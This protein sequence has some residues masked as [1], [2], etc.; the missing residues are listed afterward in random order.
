M[1][2]LVLGVVHPAVAQNASAHAA[3]VAPP[4]APAAPAPLAAECVPSCRAGYFCHE[5]QCLS[6]CNPPC[7]AGERCSQN[8]E[9]ESAT[10]PP[11][12]TPVASVPAPPAPAVVAP[13]PVAAAPPWQGSIAQVNQP[14]ARSSAAP[15]ELLRNPGRLVF[16]AR[17]GFQLAGGGHDEPSCSTTGGLSCE[18]LSNSDDDDKSLVMFGVDGMI[19]ATRGLRFGLGYQLVPYSAIRYTAAT[20]NLHLGNEHALSAIVEA[21]WPLGPQIGLVARAQAGARMIIIGGDLAEASNSFLN[22]CKLENEVH[23]DASQGPLFGPNFGLMLGAVGGGDAI[24]WRTDLAF[25]R[26]SIPLPTYTDVRSK[27]EMGTGAPDNG[28]S[29]GGTLYGTRLWL[30]AGVEL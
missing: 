2:C 8:G 9:C 3:A 7:G 25:D 16:A 10:P 12:P 15:S 24:H 4:A 26:F 28:K 23:C 27:A 17:V 19:H 6:L 20:K 29:L 21:L 22:G 18:K 30:L 11:A 13:Q 5:G 14:V 1:G